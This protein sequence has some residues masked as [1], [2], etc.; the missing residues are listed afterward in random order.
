MPDADNQSPAPMPGPVVIVGGGGAAAAAVATLVGAER[1]DVVVLTAEDIGPYDRTTLSK[2]V[3]AGERDGPP[4]LYDERLAAVDLRTRTTVTGLDLGQRAVTASGP[5]GV[6]E[7]SYGSLLLTT[8]ATPRHLPLDGAG[9]DGV[10]VLRSAA[11]A[12]AL[13]AATTDA[14][15]VVVVGGGLIGLEA[16]AALRARS[17]GVTVVEAAD[18]LLGRVLPPV[19]ADIV[20][21]AHRD[22]GVR[23]EIGVRPT[24]FVGDEAVA[25]VELDDGRVLD[26]DVVLVAIGVVPATALAEEAGL[27]TDDGVLVDQQLRTSD[28]AVLAAGD[29]VRVADGTGGHRRR[30]EAWTPALAMGQHAARTILGTPS[31]Y[32]DAPWMWSDQYDLQ[33]Q[34]VGASVEDLRQVHR[35]TADGDHGLV[36]VGLGPD[37]TVAGAAGVSLGSGVG[38]V[39]RGLQKL[40]ERGVVVEPDQLADESVDLRRLARG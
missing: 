39:V 31:A 29:V 30:T 4:P 26:A 16:A 1:T 33:V 22:A 18:R 36:V 28:A 8:G 20:A 17:V 27:A 14:R 5:D 21:Q 11:D 37:G 35:G 23:F 7:V 2:A 12:D 15:E 25:G 9:L 32:T 34:A 24:R 19:L 3:L 6:G 13:V 38:R 40:V 10:L